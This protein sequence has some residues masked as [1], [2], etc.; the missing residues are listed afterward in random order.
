M[1]TLKETLIDVRGATFVTVATNT[2]PKMKKT[3]NPFHGRV[4]KIAKYNGQINFHYDRAVL[5]QL[6]REGK[7]ASCFFAG[8]SYHKPILRE[9]GTLTPF[10]VHKDDPSRE[11]L[12]FRILRTLETS[13]VDETGADVPEAALEPW[14]DRNPNAYAN[15]GTEKKIRFITLGLTSVTAVTF[16]GEIAPIG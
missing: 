12:R 5:A 9:D 1:A 10:A 11:Y 6:E 2:E 13:Y 8:E 3:G 7:D 15:Q 16:D 14:L 4:R